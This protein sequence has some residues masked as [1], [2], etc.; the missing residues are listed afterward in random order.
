MIGYPNKQGG[1]VLP[2]R[3]FPLNL[4]LL[5]PLLPYNKSFIDYVSV[6]EH[7][8]KELDQYPAI[9]TSRLVNNAYVFI[10]SQTKWR[11][12]CTIRL[13]NFVFASWENL[14]NCYETVKYI[15]FSLG[16]PWFPRLSRTSR[17][18]RAARRWNL[19]RK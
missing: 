1:P 10:T 13:L 19:C 15:V 12:K 16:S 7:G 5:P 2:T 17:S 8:K 11:S 18:T 6:H 14:I 4:L 9:L 3:D